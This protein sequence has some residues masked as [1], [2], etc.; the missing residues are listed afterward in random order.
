M[1]AIG[2]GKD[3]TAIDGHTE[4]VL[5]VM[6]KQT[7]IAINSALAIEK[8]KKQEQLL[9]LQNELLIRQQE[10]LENQEPAHSTAKI[11]TARS[12]QVKIA[13]FGHHVPR[14]ANSYEWD[15]RLFPIATAPT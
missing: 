3:S 8:L 9:D 2:N 10:E 12:S 13:I 11:A 7:A 14:I 5:A 6:G 4:Q 1:L 15:Y